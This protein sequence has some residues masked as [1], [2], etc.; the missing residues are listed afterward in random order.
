MKKG[1]KFTPYDYAIRNW[2]SPKDKASLEKS[3]RVSRLS[4]K[5]TTMIK[6]I[7]FGGKCAIC[8][9]SE[10]ALLD[11]HHIVEVCD[12]GKNHIDNMI[13]LCAND[14]RRIHSKMRTLVSV[15]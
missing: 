8:G 15:A 13:C 12:G 9:C 4:S 7:K 10:S 5:Y 1:Y 6:N 14:H 3:G 11:L 2:D